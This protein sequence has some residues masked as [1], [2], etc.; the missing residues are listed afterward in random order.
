M[1]ISQIKVVVI[2]AG[3]S[4]LT[5]AYRLQQ[6]KINV[7]VYEARGRV[8][9]RIF[10]AKL[11]GEYVELGG[12]NIKDGGNAG[13]IC[14]LM[15]EF[16]LKQTKRRISLDYQYF[17]GSALIAKDLLYN[18]K[19]VPEDLQSQLT[20]ATEKSTNMKEVLRDLFSEN[21][22]LYKVLSVRLAAYE[23]APVE[24]LSALYTDTLYHMILGG[25]S[26]VHQSANLEENYV[27]MVSIQGGN[28]LL[29]EKLAESLHERIHLNMPLIA[30]SKTA[31]PFYELT[32]VNGEKVKA[33]ILV[34]AI[35][36]SVYRDI[37]FENNF[38]PEER[39]EAI[40]NIQYGTNAKIL[41]ASRDLY[42]SDHSD[43]SIVTLTKQCC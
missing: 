16:S 30:I 37:H 21:D 14:R 20:H 38:I 39:L 17:D 4:G 15:D 43:V 25:L 13:N 26:S 32:F 22:P 41:A 27:D 35:P 9:G 19:F 34:L 12:Q 24:K 2:G 29:P 3:I 18:K 1:T 28:A 40:A 42:K 31:A 6:K 23:G 36:C 11:N 8:G 7:H 33:D 10:T 5:T